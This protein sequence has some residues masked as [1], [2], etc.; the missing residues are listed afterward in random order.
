MAGIAPK[1]PLSTSKTDIGYDLTRNLKETIQQNFKNLLLTSP[2]EKVFDINFGVGIRRFLFEQS[3][4][5]LDADI[6]NRISEQ[7]GRYMPFINIQKISIDR[8]SDYNRAGISIVYNV[9]S[10][11]VSNILSL[12]ISSAN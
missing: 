12:D 5:Q 11:S 7:T 3:S 1:L 2:G 8:N 6:M 10:V 9:P 4:E